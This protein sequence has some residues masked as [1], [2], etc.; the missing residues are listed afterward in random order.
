MTSFDHI[1]F[2]ST[3]I[4]EDIKRITLIESPTSSASGV[5]G[6]LDVIAAAFEGTGAALERRRIDEQYGDML[7]MRCDPGRTEPGILVL[8]HVDTVHP[9]GT[10]D[11]AL[12]YRRAGDKIFGPGIYDMKGGIVLAI[13][14]FQRLARANVTRP[15]PLTF[16]YTPDEEVGS[17][18][19]RRYIEAEAMRNRYVLV[20]EPKRNGGKIV[21]QRKGTGRFDIH[22][23]GRPAHAGANHAKGRSAIRA[24]AR[25][26]LE[27][28]AFTDYARGVTTNVGVIRG[29][30]VA[31]VVPEHCSIEVDFR[32]GDLTTAK[33]VECRFAELRST[34]P[35]VE[36]AV[37][38]GMNR[39]PFV[40]DAGVEAL[41]AGA[42]AVARKIGIELESDAVS[43][44]GSDGNFTA[45]M[46]IATL[47]GLGIDGDGAHTH[48]EHMLFSSIAPGTRLMQGL[49]ETLGASSPDAT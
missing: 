18:A 39:P 37:A 24:M 11:G 36:I 13:A 7:C 3:A 30:S 47:D 6:V 33:E 26:I 48:D 41:F 40:R 5:N 12:A 29:G 46:G 49:F 44:G 42:A 21:T 23:R 16:L 15:L 17:L 14:A 32:V 2:D 4:L 34:D 25:I 9:P 22:A 31:N 45:A 10:L 38:G 8:S 27:V 19:S 20:T 35:D 43:G 1:D 28:E